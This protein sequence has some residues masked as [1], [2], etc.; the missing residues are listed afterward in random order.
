[1]L[2]FCLCVVIMKVKHGVTN[3]ISTDDFGRVSAV[4]TKQNNR[5]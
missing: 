2:R 5:I 4:T 1:M 3:E